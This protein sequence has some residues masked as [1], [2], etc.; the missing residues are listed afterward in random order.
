VKF[1]IVLALRVLQEFVKMEEHVL[2]PMK[3]VY[4]L[5]ITLE[6]S[7]NIPLVDM[8]VNPAIVGAVITVGALIRPKLAFVAVVTMD[9]IVKF[10]VL[11]GSLAVQVPAKIME[12]VVWQLAIVYVLMAGEEI[13][14]T[15]QQMVGCVTVRS[16]TV[17]VMENATFPLVIVFVTVA[18]AG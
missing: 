12:S 18:I 17:K 14:V 8:F 1:Q 9:S 15:F 10:Q 7:A 6:T 3:D 13:S 4:V 16:V 5:K 2:L 11:L